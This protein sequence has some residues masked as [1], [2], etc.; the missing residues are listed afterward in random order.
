[1]A[2]MM[3]LLYSDVITLRG[4]PEFINSI[5]TVC[6]IRLHFS[7]CEIKDEMEMRNMI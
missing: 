5:Y 7:V 1:M 6:G 3:S 2:I 4:I